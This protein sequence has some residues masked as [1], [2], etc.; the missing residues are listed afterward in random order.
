VGADQ[1]LVLDHGRI[2]ERGTH[3]ELLVLDQ[4][5]AQLCRQSLLESSPQRE[6]ESDEEIATSEVAEP[7][8]QRLPV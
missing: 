3:D 6:V 4:R 1:I 8:E 2:V 7:E 5:Y